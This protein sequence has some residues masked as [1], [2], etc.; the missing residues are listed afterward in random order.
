MRAFMQ[1][2]KG[3]NNSNFV[4]VKELV[5]KLHSQRTRWMFHIWQKDVLFNVLD[6]I[7]VHV[8]MHISMALD[9][10]SPFRRK[11]QPRVVNIY[12]PT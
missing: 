1:K 9:K 2:N 12:K 6:E 8:N 7:F 5:I 11:G 10:M 3:L 4:R